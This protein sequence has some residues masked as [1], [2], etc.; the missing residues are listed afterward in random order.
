MPNC[1]KHAFLDAATVCLGRVNSALD[2]GD[3]ERICRAWVDFMAL[4][5]RMLQRGL[6][7][8]GGRAGSR[9]MRAQA[10]RVLEEI[11]ADQPGAPSLWERSDA[12]AA[13]PAADEAAARARRAH[14]LLRSGLASRAATA[15]VQDALA[16]V[17]DERVRAQAWVLHP[18]PPAGS[19]MP[20]LPA[21]APFVGIEGEDAEKRLYKLIQKRL[22]NGS[23]PGPSG[24]TGEH[25][26]LVAKHDTN[27][28]VLA[29]MVSYLRNGEP[30]D[31]LRTYILACRLLLVAKPESSSV[32]PVAVGDVLFRLASITAA[33]DVDDDAAEL[34]QP[35]EF[36][37]GVRGGPE[38]AAVITQ[39]L[40]LSDPS[41][42]DAGAAAAAA[43][44]EGKL[45]AVTADFCNAFNASWRT[46]VLGRFLAEPRFQQA[47]RFAH[48][49]YRS[50]SLLL[51]QNRASVVVEVLSSAEGTRQGDP[52]SCVLFAW[53]VHGVYRGVLAAHPDV[54]LVTVMD[55]ATL[56]GE[57]G[58]VGPAFDT[59]T[60]L[61]REQLGLTA[62]LRKCH[63]LWLHTGQEG[64]GGGTPP[65]LVLQQWCADRNVALQVGATKVLGAPTGCDRVAVQAL[66]QKTLEKHERFFDA[67]LQEELPRQCAVTL[68]RLCG[69]PRFNYLRRTVIPQW[70]SDTA[71]AIDNLV[72]DTFCKKLNLEQPHGDSVQQQ[73]LQLPTRLGGIG[74]TSM[75]LTSPAAFLASLGQAAAHLRSS[76]RVDAVLRNNVLQSAAQHALRS[77]ANVVDPL[78][79]Q[80]PPQGPDA[81]LEQVLEHY[82]ARPLQRDS[83]PSPLS[84]VPRPLSLPPPPPPPLPPPN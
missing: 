10:M 72:L 77:L 35:I 48:W 49:A 69:V 66:L 61:A 22:A 12:E 81:T 16:D 5:A 75:Q 3:R 32:R 13:H 53:G 42:G 45:A 36:G 47:W 34:M 23:A 21:N 80:L 37:V 27:L 57:A 26:L 18:Q 55:D 14:S 65:P 29:R 6:R 63:A 82:G 83:A 68:L 4:P 64:E 58:S 43:S 79:P 73:L 56:F 33:V 39:A 15:L 9:T 28:R 31:E 20:E 70:F 67:L 24:L 2:S 52:L 8:R 40:L 41:D 7:K 51:L 38:V 11:R 76:A 17:D 54:L 84:T 59:L 71:V 19:V 1:L 60:R 50:P 62:N 78:P 74:L 44:A 46:V 30:A 25:L